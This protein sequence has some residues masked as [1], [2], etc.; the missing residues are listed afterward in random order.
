L[1]INAETI[2]QKHS[3]LDKGEADGSQAANEDLRRVRFSPRNAFYLRKEGHQLA[4]KEKKE[5]EPPARAGN[6]NG[7]PYRRK[8]GRSARPKKNMLEKGKNNYKGKRR[9][10][11]QRG[12]G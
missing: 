8:K 6:K 4:T 11:L 3:V 1:A 10:S 9:T 5:K 7:G 2:L 12:D